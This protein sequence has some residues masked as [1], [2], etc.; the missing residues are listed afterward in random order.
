MAR[1]GGF[2]IRQHKP[3]LAGGLAIALACAWGARQLSF[4][5]RFSQYFSERFAFR[6]ATDILEKRL[7]GLT[8][9]EFSLPA[10]VQHGAADPQFLRQVSRF[11]SWGAL[12]E[13]TTSDPCCMPHSCG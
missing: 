9:L 1:L 10:R 11:T 5:D 7:S 3:L 13:W 4:D 12:T 8:V 2:V 6:Q